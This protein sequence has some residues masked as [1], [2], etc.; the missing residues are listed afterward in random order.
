MAILNPIESHS[1][2]SNP[3]NLAINQLN[4]LQFMAIGIHRFQ[5]VISMLFQWDYTQTINGGLSWYLGMSENGV[6]P[7]L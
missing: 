3:I 5:P 6:Y 2:P 1:I 7:Q 4:Y